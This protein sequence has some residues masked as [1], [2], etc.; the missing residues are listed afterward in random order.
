MV[1]TAVLPDPFEMIPPLLGVP[2]FSTHPPQ[3]LNFDDPRDLPIGFE[4][5]RT[6]KERLLAG[7]VKRGHKA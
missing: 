6:T 4:R 1:V 2:N 7:T 5:K 3:K